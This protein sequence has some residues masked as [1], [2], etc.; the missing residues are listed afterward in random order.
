VVASPATPEYFQAVAAALWE[1][2]AIGKADLS[3]ICTA[4]LLWYVKIPEWTI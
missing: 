1:I 3:E 4:K 2:A